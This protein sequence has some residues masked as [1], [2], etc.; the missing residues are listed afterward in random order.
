M[1][2]LL[3]IG[4][5]CTNQL[6]ASSQIRIGTACRLLETTYVTKTL[7]LTCRTVDGKKVWTKTIPDGFGKKYGVSVGGICPKVGGL[8]WEGMARV[9]CVRVKGINRYQIKVYPKQSPESKF[10]DEELKK[11]VRKADSVKVNVRL[12]ISY[13]PSYEN[14]L[15]AK[16]IIDGLNG[17]LRLLSSMD[18]GLEKIPP[19]LI[20]WDYEW[21]KSK[22]PS[23]CAAWAMNAG[24]GVCGEELMFFNLGWNSTSGNWYL[25]DPNRFQDDAQKINIAGNIGHE[26]AHLAQSW[27]Q[28]RANNYSTSTY[29]KDYRPAWLR[30]GAVEVFKSLSYAYV[31]NLS[32]TEARNLQVHT[33]GNR[34]T[35]ISLKDLSE[36]KTYKTLCEY[37]N[38]SLAMEYLVAKAKD[39]NALFGWERTDIE[40]QPLDQAG[41][42]QR[43]FGLDFSRFM[44]EADAY[45]KQET[46]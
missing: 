30:E 8:Y 18:I 14:T 37:N 3:V 45:I 9:E 11:L 23:Y 10:I 15:W 25:N 1:L 42:F 46:K 4:F 28:S 32:Y 40:A 35:S 6:P 26:V 43:A 38:G 36:P 5:V 2:Q 33:F 19:I 17:T 27:V 13:Q 16:S 7:H 34:C 39:L 41:A 21:A 29:F 31:N 12:E 24:G 44:T 20:F 22:L